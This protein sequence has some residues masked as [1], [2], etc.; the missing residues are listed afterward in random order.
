MVAAKND[1]AHHMLEKQFQGREIEKIY[2]AILS[3][4]PK[5]NTGRIESAIGRHPINRKKMAVL[6]AGGRSA[7]TLYEVKEKF[8]EFS[9][10]KLRLETG[11][12]HQI[13]VHMA[14]IGCPVAGDQVY[15]KKYKGPYSLNR[16]L[17][18]SSTI[19]FNHPVSGEWLTFTA[20]LW[21]DMK[22]FLN[23]LRS[24]VT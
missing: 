16:Q 20:P 14:S 9:Y 3:G 22:D 1:Q 8:G 6:R 13:R 24:H 12:T 11:R 21:H 5:N 23:E 4:V 2:H 18:H 19:S 17:L 10:V 15:G 7:V